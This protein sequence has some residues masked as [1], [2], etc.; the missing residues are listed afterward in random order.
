MQIQF[1]LTMATI[2]ACF[3]AIAAYGIWLGLK[4]TEGLLGPEIASH[5]S[6]PSAF[7]LSREVQPSVILRR[8]RR[9]GRYPSRANRGVVIS[10]GAAQLHAG[11]SF[12][13][14]MPGR[15]CAGRSYRLIAERPLT[16]RS[17]L[18]HIE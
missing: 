14:R 10:Y 8:T 1:M 11:A 16:S 17:I 5:Q 6:E 12:S 7:D 13:A 18:R 4:E 9:F 3:F 15:H 2:L